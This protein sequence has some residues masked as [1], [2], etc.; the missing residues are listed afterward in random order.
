M[1]GIQLGV[2]E[3]VNPPALL[4]GY[5]GGAR[6][7]QQWPCVVATLRLFRYIIPPNRW[8]GEATEGSGSTSHPCP[9]GSE[10][11]PPEIQS[12]GLTE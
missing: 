8:L 7:A 10:Q 9:R 2:V 3:N 1:V 5:I 12:H 6:L 4:A 11:T